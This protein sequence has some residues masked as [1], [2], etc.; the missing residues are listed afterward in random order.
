MGWIVICE[1]LISSNCVQISVGHKASNCYLRGGG[2]GGVG[3]GGESVL[4]VIL[5]KHISTCDFLGE[6]G[7][8]L[9]LMSPPTFTNS[10]D[11]DETPHS[12]TRLGVSCIQRVNFY[13]MSA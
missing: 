7:L 8:G 5:R 12:L 9:D 3:G 6:G 11:S 10:V 2:G 4:P 13:Y 1:S